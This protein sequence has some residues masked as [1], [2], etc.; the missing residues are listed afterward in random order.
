M[1]TETVWLLATQLKATA[2][3]LM[4]IQRGERN[5]KPRKEMEAQVKLLVERLVTEVSK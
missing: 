3:Y 2:A 1:D 5:P 4:K